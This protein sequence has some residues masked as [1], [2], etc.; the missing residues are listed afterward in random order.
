MTVLSWNIRL[1]GRVDAGEGRD[2]YS[3]PPANV[4]FMLLSLYLR[5]FILYNRLLLPARS[6]WSRARDDI[7][8]Q[9]NTQNK[10]EIC[11]KNTLNGF[12]DP[13]RFEF[14]GFV[15]LRNISL[16]SWNIYIFCFC[17]SSPC[18]SSWHKQNKETSLKLPWRQTR[19][20][21]PKSV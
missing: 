17:L 9:C 6:W 12:T 15:H 8:L 16:K 1:R 20:W 5:L 10:G 11:L 13:S 4:S 18:S 19:I 14:T 21:W 2:Q 7:C 3:K